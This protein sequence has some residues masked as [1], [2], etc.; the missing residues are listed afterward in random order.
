MKYAFL[1]DKTQLSRLSLAVCQKYGSL[2][3]RSK[4]VSVIGLFDEKELLVSN[5][6]V[7]SKI[8]YLIIN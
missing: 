2:Y 5:E 4:G 6:F 3:L 8:L 7:K 1:G